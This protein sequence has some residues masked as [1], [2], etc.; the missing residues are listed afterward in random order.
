MKKTQ[1]DPI[2]LRSIDGLSQSGSLIA[3]IA[4]F[5]LLINVVLDVLGRWLFNHPVNGT[6]EY[7]SYWWMPI[8]VFL[9][10]AA[11]QLRNEHIQIDYLVD[12]LPPATRKTVSIFCLSI[13]IITI[14]ALAY[15]ALLDALAAAEV[16][17]AAYGTAEVLIWPIKFVAVAGLILFA[18]QLAASLYRVCAQPKSFATADKLPHDISDDMPRSKSGTIGLLFLLIISLAIISAF[19]G[20]P[21]SREI[22]GILVI[23]LVLTTVNLG[24]PIGLALIIASSLGL[25]KLRG[26]AALESAL[27]ESI[28]GGAATWQLSVIPLF[29][30][31]GVALWHSGLT[32]KA[33]SSARVF[34]GNLPGGLAVGT[35]F[36]GAILAAASGS[37]VG[38]SYALGRIAIPEMI[39]AKYPPSL[40]TGVVAMAGTLGQ[41]IPPSILLVVYAG[42]VQTPVGPQLLSGVVPGVILATAFAA[43]IVLRG[44]INPAWAPTTKI[45]DITWRGRYHAFIVLLP[46]IL[47]ILVIIGGLFGGVFTPTE[48]GA[49]GALS[50][51]LIGWLLN[52]AQNR[53]PAKAFTFTRA[54][55]L[56]AVIATAGI[57]LLLIGVDILTKV[58]TLSRVAHHVS[59]IVLMM[60]LSRI[61]FLLVLVPIYLV[62]GMFLDPMAMILLTVPVFVPTLEALDINLLWFGVFVIMMAEIGIVTPPIGILSF[63]VH[64]IAQSKEVNLGTSIRLSDVF[65]GVI[66]F[67]LVALGIVLILIFF[68]NIVTWLPDMSRA[69]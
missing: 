43:M 13:A 20:L 28:Y 51:L 24:I 58:M 53:S 56:D 38:I 45:P 29:I 46:I 47:I 50:A 57:F 41:L 31:M 40:A 39:R 34:L 6:I 52:G 61:T 67:I 62:L 44:V 66:P 5:V 32:T 9:A 26:G 27:E 4:C 68:P 25:W 16:K 2:W 42:V 49:F 10:F 17:Q 11:A 8:I 22:T 19:F 33:Y 48:A 36:A 21:L 55:L 1:T 35:N 12:H 14:L 64:R 23:C 60:E 7:V 30:L 65:I 37:T 63:I 15:Y 3:A 59:E 18:L 69:T 54:C